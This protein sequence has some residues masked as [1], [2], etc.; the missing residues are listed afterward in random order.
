MLSYL[1]TPMIIPVTAT[2]AAGKRRRRHATMGPNAEAEMAS[3]SKKPADE[4]RSI[5]GLTPDK[6]AQQIP[7]PPVMETGR[8]DE[9]DSTTKN[10]WSFSERLDPRLKEIQVSPDAVRERQ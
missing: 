4:L 7:P 9:K 6:P 2:I 3:K 1:F 5:L 10:P 8:R